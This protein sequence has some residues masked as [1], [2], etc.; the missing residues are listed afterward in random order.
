[1]KFEGSPIPSEVGYR[2]E[3]YGSIKDVLYGFGLL[4]TR[5]EVVTEMMQ[6]LMLFVGLKS[7]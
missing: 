2:L 3:V 4:N 6:D 7:A 5:S 1:M